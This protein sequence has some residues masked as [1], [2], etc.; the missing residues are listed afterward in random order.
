M[1]SPYHTGLN[2]RNFNGIFNWTATYRR[3]SDINVPYFRVQRKET[4]MTTIAYKQ[5]VEEILSSKSGSLIAYMNSNCWAKHT[6]RL[7]Y[8]RELNN[9]IPVD[10]YGGCGKQRCPR[11]S[12]DCTKKLA[13]HK[14]YLSMENSHCRDYVT[15]KVAQPLLEW[16][17]VPV[18]MGGADPGNYEDLLPPGSYIH[19]SGFGSPKELAEYLLLL[20][21]Y[22]TLY[23]KYH[24]WRQSWEKA[25]NGYMCEYCQKLDEYFLSKKNVRYERYRFKDANQQAGETI[26]QFVTRLRS[27]AITCEFPD[28]DDAIADQVMDK[29]RSNADCC[30]NLI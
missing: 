24:R 20:D 11:G 9:Y 1:E 15:E 13:R 6:K 21:K 16:Q 7:S 26:A 19:T 12:M 10:T 23:E 18:V 28:P 5:L 22:P 30:E 25:N 29:C 2:I 8:I 3:D 17:A 4:N 27:I 14:F